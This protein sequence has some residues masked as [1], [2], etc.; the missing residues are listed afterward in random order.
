MSNFVTQYTGKYKIS[1]HRF[2]YVYHYILDRYPA[3]K[4]E[5]NIIADN[6]RS[7]QYGDKDGG[8]TGEN[9][10]TQ[11]TALRLAYLSRK[12]E[13]IET[14]AKEAG[15]DLWPYILQAAT[16]EKCSYK[17]LRMQKDRIPCNEKEYYA[18]RRKFYWIMSKALK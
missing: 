6:R 3:W 18:A 12:I 14:A 11:K 9:D 13:K 17:T 4:E 5:Y 1:R 8:K 10:P 15:G 2:L 16:T 7:F